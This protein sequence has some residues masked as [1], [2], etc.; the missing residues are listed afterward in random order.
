M[1]STKGFL[2]RYSLQSFGIILICAILIR[3]FLFSSYVMSGS[4][5]LPTIWP[6]DFLIASKVRINELKRGE[7]VAMRCPANKDKLCLKRVVAVS[8]D[9]VE[10]R[11]DA[12]MINGQVARYIP[13][14]SFQTEIVGGG[15]WGIWPAK[16][17][18]GAG[19]PVVVPPQNIYLLNDKRS[20]RDDSRTWGPVAMEYLEAR[21]LGVWMS[22]DWYDGEHVRAWPR[23]RWPRMFHSID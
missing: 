14:G 19:S 22:L 10:Y 3:T 16:S 13:A 18:D 12:L 21:V 15:S 11:G 17:N 2:L 23:I 9:R 7:V 20:D 8:G 4:A 1:A 6:G 5:M